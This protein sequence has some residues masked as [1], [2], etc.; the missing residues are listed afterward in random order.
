MQPLWVAAKFGY[1]RRVEYELEHGADMERMCGDSECTPMHISIKTNMASAHSTAMCL[2]KN[3]ANV[4]CRDKYNNTPL[5]DAARNGSTHIVLLLLLAK[6][7]VGIVNNDG[8]TALSISLERQDV[9]TS[10]L[11]RNLAGKF[12][13]CRLTRNGGCVLTR[14][15]GCVLSSR[16]GDQ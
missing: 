7:H 11:L 9:E 12:C 14:N 15:E 10:E 16:C 6:A 3:G 13:R 4:N 2:I 5:H 8:D 1:I